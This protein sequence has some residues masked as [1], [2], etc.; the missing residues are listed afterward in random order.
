MNSIENLANKI[1]NMLDNM[2]TKTYPIN[3]DSLD[4]IMLYR[5]RFGNVVKPHIG[6]NSITNS[7]SCVKTDYSFAL[8]YLSLRSKIFFKF[9]KVVEVILKGASFITY[10]ICNSLIKICVSVSTFVVDLN[11]SFENYINRKTKERAK[12]LYRYPIKLTLDD[13]QHSRRYG[14]VVNSFRFHTQ[15]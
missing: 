15:K 1:R 7:I 10:H 13:I 11:E 14:G 9:F 8:K 12:K 3:K 2:K 4:Y 5:N 6:K